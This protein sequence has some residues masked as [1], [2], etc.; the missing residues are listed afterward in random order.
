MVSRP[1]FLANHGRD[2]NFPNIDLPVSFLKGREKDREEGRGEER[3]K[4]RERERERERE[5]QDRPQL[6]FHYLV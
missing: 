1:Q 4:E 6:T 5:T 2:F 3:E